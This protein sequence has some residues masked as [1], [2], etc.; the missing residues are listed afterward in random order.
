MEQVQP[1][2]YITD[3]SIESCLNYVEQLN[4]ISQTFGPE[5]PIVV[6]I[7]SPGGS[8]N[9]F[10]IIYDALKNS[11]NPIITYTVG[12]AASAG[13]FLFM[14][15]ASGFEDHEGNI[16]R[17]RIV[18]ENAQLMFHG[19]QLGGI[20]GSLVEVEEA[21][22]TARVINDQLFT[23]AYKTLGLNSIQELKDLVR[24]RTEAHDFNMS[25]KVAVELGF[26]DEIATIKMQP[27]FM[28]NIG[29]IPTQEE[30]KEESKEELPQGIESE[31]TIRVKE[32]FKKQKRKKKNKNRK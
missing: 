20:D 19:V 18:G 30:V 2:I 31:I 14:S 17:K 28:Y 21:V 10:S 9:G 25:A 1:K 29:I 27:V 8:V 26:A 4:R 32:E 5:Q 24:S 23:I 12:L 15:V 6:Q 3:F 7:E 22:K 16:V 13:L 11:D